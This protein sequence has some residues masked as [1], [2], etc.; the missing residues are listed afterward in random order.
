VRAARVKR[1]GRHRGW[2]TGAGREGGGD[3][4]G[5]APHP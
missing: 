4:G 3:W 5:G 2:T 1:H